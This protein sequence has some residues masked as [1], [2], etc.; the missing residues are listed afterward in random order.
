MTSMRSALFTSLLSLTLA[1]LAGT[2]P[3]AAFRL[4]QLQNPGRFDTGPS[5]TCDDPNGF[6]HWNTLALTW[7]INPA[8]QGTGKGTALASALE[9]WNDVNGAGHVLTSGGATTAGF[10]TD[11]I[12]TITWESNGACTGTCLAVTAL[13]VQAGQ[14]IV[15]SDILMNNDVSWKTNGTDVDTEAVLAHELGHTLGIHHS[16]VVSNPLPTLHPFYF[17]SAER[18]LEA[19]DRSALQCAY[20]RYHPCTAAPATPSFISGPS[21][22]L[23]PTFTNAVFWTEHIPGA[24]SY[25]WEII[26][27]LVRSNTTNDLAFGAGGQGLE[28]GWKTIRVRAENACGVSPWRTASFR[29]LPKTDPACGGCSGRVC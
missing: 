29:V 20:S 19:D 1:A 3:A 17:G 11:N 10:V 27:L 13:V 24:A 16:E 15:E 8:N 9:S 23:C 21:Q 4:I 28:P 2:P 14:I 22:D 18:T 12:N 5:T 6:I 25:R 7:R 26:G